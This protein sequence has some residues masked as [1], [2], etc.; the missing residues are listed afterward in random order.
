MQAVRHVLISDSTVHIHVHQQRMAVL[1]PD[2]PWIAPT[3]FRSPQNNSNLP[4]LK[5]HNSVEHHHV[6][7][8]TI[9]A[10]ATSLPVPGLAADWL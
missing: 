8:P 4:C 5:Y 2:R 1:S 9:T 10:P 7:A 3:H 6:A